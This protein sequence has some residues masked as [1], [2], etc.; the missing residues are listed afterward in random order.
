MGVA[1]FWGAFTMTIDDKGRLTIPSSFR[2][3]LDEQIVVRWNKDDRTIEIFSADG[4]TNFYQH[5][6][7]LP[8]LDSKTQFIR[9]MVGADA[10]N[11]S[12]DKQGRVLI[13]GE[14]KERAGIQGGQAIVTGAMDRVKVWS[15]ETWAAAKTKWETEDFFNEFASK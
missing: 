13:P 4:W 3:T 2:K 14:F 7:S 15:P 10:F 11:V 8:F 9:T 5:I 6:M 1:G 12:I